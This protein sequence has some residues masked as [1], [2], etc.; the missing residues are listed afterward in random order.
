[1]F[2]RSNFNLRYDLW[3]SLARTVPCLREFA[4]RLQIA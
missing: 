3:R 2:G 4:E 1:V